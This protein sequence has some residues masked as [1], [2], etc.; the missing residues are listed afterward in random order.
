M[1]IARSA[2]ATLPATALLAASLTSA[3]GEEKIHPELSELVREGSTEFFVLLEEQADLSHAGAHRTKVE[4]TRDESKVRG[5]AL[6]APLGRERA[7]GYA[8]RVR[9]GRIRKGITMSVGA[10]GEGATVALMVREYL[11]ET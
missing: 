10:A 3:S 4:R 9:P 5:P 2:L 7:F 1:F 8:R 11:K 6:P